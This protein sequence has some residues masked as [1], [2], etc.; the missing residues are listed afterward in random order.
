MKTFSITI[1]HF[2]FH[3]FGYEKL[4]FHLAHWALFDACKLCQ[5]NCSPGQ[6]GSLQAPL[7][8]PG[9]SPGASP[10]K[11]PSPPSPPGAAN[12]KRSQGPQARS[13]QTAPSPPGLFT[14]NGPKAPRRIHRKRPLSPPQ[15]I[16]RKRPQAPQPHLPQTVPGTPRHS[17]QTVPSP[18]SA[19]TANGPKRFQAK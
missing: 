8:S 5:V 9:A 4:L 13:A 16:H 11:F 7:P 14:A 2:S 18:S 17:L 19:F 1:F 10:P 15:P 6:G 12:G 3:F